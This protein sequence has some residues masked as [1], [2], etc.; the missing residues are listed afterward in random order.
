MKPTFHHRLVNREYED[1]CLF[2]RMLREK[3]AFLFDVGRID[4]LRPG[5]LLKITDVFVT[6][7]HIDHFIGFDTLLRTFLRR[8]IPL[9]VYG[10]ENI[11]ECVEGKLRG[12]TWNL[13]EEYPIKIEVFSIG[14]SEIR[15]SSFYAENSFRR[16]DRDAIAFEGIALREPPFTVRTGVFSHGIPCLGFSLE[17]DFHINIDKA[18]LI[19]MDLPVGPWLGLLK[20]MIREKAEPDTSMTVGDREFAFSELSSIARITSGQKVSYLTDISPEEDNIKRAIELIRDSDSL[21]CEAYF[22]DED[23]QRAV[24]RH[25]LTA[26]IAGEIAR[27][28]NVKNLVPMHFS[29]K[30]SDRLNELEAEAMREY[31]RQV[32][33]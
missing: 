22:L 18:A 12:Y 2:V 1:P 24:E 26:R 7:M 32:A 11:I 16:A 20:K 28:A 31:G 4:N 30:Y 3:R 9:R 33:N 17:E 15:H 23:M 27:N 25:H 19:N 14:P 13:I 29:P 6:H 5:D 21:Y 10:P 8:D